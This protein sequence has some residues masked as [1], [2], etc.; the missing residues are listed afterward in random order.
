MQITWPCWTFTTG[1]PQKC[2]RA[3]R[4]IC[5]KTLPNICGTPVDHGLPPSAQALLGEQADGTTYLLGGMQAQLQEQ[6]REQRAH[7]AIDLY[8][9]D[10]LGTPMALTDQTGQVAWAAK[11][12]PWG[13]VLKKCNPQRQHH[14][15]ETGAYYNRDRH[16]DLMVRIYV[17]QDS[18]CQWRIFK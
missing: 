1:R 7:I 5:S 15:R 8:H 3:C 13:N 6:E 16:C 9:C 17:N 11:L 2:W 12:H 10:H 4:V 18:I 14:D